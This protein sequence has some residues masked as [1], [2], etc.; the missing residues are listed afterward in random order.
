MTSP[1]QAAVE[2]RA[3]KIRSEYS[4]LDDAAGIAHAMGCYAVA[5]SLRRLA[6]I[7][8]AELRKVLRPLTRVS[9]K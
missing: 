2:M 9:G 1:A 8:Q 4:T 6:E 5:N 3:S 7:K